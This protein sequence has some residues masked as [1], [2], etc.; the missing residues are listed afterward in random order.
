[1]LVQSIYTH[2]FEHKNCYYLYN[3]QHNLFVEITKSLYETLYNRDYSKLPK[4]DI[5]YLTNKDIIVDER[6]KYVY[7]GETKLKFLASSVNEDHLGL[8]IV[9]T[10]GCNFNCSYCF[11]KKENP[12]T[13]S[14]KIEDGII[15]FINE[16]KNAKSLD[17]TWYGG[18][19]LLAFDN[20]TSLF[21]KI[22]QNTDIVIE[23]HS[24]ITNGYLINDRVI[25]FME[26]SRI[27]KVQITLDGSRI[28]H[29][30]LRFLRGSKRPTF[31]IIMENIVKTARR[32]PQTKISVRVNLNRNNESDFTEIY[33]YFCEEVGLK[34]ISVYPGFIREDRA[35]GNSMCYNTIGGKDTIRFYE[36]LKSD[37]VNVNFFPQKAPKGCMI[38]QLNSYII[39]PKGELYKCWNDVGNKSKIIGS[40]QE[41]E[42]KNRA[43]YYNYLHE[44]SF[45]TD[46]RCKDCLLFPICSGGCGWY[47]F[48][49]NFE[50][51]EFDICTHFHD[52][53]NLEKSLINSLTE[54]NSSLKKINI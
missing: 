53:I 26:K 35:D 48:R 14:I 25:S 21:N 37:G 4:D 3:S 17:L 32:L 29:N 41:K 9:P 22:R 51:G 39:G 47:R 24:I 10:T 20:I 23:K 45:L 44:V 46:K 43:L 33:K 13:M 11:E 6:E 30:R 15:S 1:M 12:Q 19:P 49:N 36:Q 2:I 54:S 8:I 18:E 42:L 50:K 40:I 38:N 5:T 27:N 16:H 52:K 28:N 34:N 7:W 31:D